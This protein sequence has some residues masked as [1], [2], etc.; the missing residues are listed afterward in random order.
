[1]P[2]TPP[3]SPPGLPEA[4]NRPDSVPQMIVQRGHER[5]RRTSALAVLLSTA[6]LLLGACG[7]DASKVATNDITKVGTGNKTKPVIT[8][9][10]ATSSTTTPKPF[11]ADDLKAVAADV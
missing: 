4:R 8:V 2:S 6:V 9:P 1:M 11:T 5:R 10:S 7:I 3:G